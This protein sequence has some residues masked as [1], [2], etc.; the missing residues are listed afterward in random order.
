MRIASAYGRQHGARLAAV[1]RLH[2]HGTVLR[3]NAR[4]K[5][6]AAHGALRPVVEIGHDAINGAVAHVARTRL[7]EIRAL[8]ATVAGLLD[9]E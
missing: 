5:D 3:L 1:A 6:A 4:S 9:H 8:L 7:L 2:A